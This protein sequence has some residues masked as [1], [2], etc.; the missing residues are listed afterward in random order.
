MIPSA[1]TFMSYERLG[2]VGILLLVLL[3]ALMVGNRVFG[4]VK[5]YGTKVLEQLNKQT[6]ALENV[7]QSNA[8]MEVGQM[9]L[10]ARMDDILRCPARPCPLR[11]SD[12]L[13]HHKVRELNPNS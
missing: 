4:W 7:K 1:E 11:P 6:M 5:E 9:R 10:H 8:S 12:H 13:P 2:I 3:I